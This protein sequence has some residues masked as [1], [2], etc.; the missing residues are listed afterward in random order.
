MNKDIIISGPIASGKSWISFAIAGTHKKVITTNAN[1]LKKRLKKGFPGNLSEQYSLM[2][3]DGCTTN[4]IL[5]LD[6]ML[7]NFPLSDNWTGELYGTDKL[8]IVYLTQDDVTNKSLGHGHF[9]II[10][11]RN[12]HL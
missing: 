7:G 8:P 10:N 5:E 2:V 4:D 12:A 3:I 1:Q 11:C 6:L 9:H